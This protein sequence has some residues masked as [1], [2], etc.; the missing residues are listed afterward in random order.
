MTSASAST[1]TTDCTDITQITTAPNQMKPLEVSI[2][3]SNLLEVKHT[4][5]VKIR[6]S[7]SISAKEYK[8]LRQDLFK[9]QKV[10]FEES[11]GTKFTVEGSSKWLETHL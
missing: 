4:K 8:K 5:R 7:K 1:A 11:I 6:S 10:D 2:D 3:S 9:V